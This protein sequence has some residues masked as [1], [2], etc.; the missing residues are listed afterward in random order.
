VRC[1]LTAATVKSL[2]TVY[3]AM[4]DAV[5]SMTTAKTAQHAGIKT[6][7]GES[8]DI[9]AKQG[10][11]AGVGL[12]RYSVSVLDQAAGYATMANYGKYQEPYF[13]SQVLDPSGA[14][15]WEKADHTAPPSS[16]WS[17]DVG[18]DLSYVLEQVYNANPGVKIGRRAAIKPG[19]QPYQNTNQTSDAWMA[20]YTP[21]LATA[22]WVGSG[23]GTSFPLRD[24]AHGNINVYGAGLPGSIWRDYMVAALKN[25]QSLG[26]Q[27]PLHAGDKAGNAPR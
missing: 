15:L 16:A 26:F 3:W 2:D 10:L 20:G 21:Q 25:Q 14:V 7:D 22:V 17:S 12:G 24:K 8:V 11:N 1:S 5:G 18:R 9:K 4:T 19:S 6:L 27:P 13:I 23:T